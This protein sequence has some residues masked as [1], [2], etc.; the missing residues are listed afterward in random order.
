MALAFGLAMAFGLV[1]VQPVQ[2]TKI[3]EL[4]ATNGTALK[5]F[6]HTDALFGYPK[7]GKSIT[8]FL[9]HAGQGCHAKDT[10]PTLKY[11]FDS[12]DYIVLVDRG[13]CR[14]DEKVRHAEGTAATCC[15]FPVR[16]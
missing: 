11:L 7:Y 4:D 3:Y 10:S 13:G 12:P 5:M 16:P 15:Q 9:Y 8:G 2:G 14:F 6:S 1:L